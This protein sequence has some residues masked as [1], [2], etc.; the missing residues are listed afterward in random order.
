MRQT[1][2]LC[3]FALIVTPSLG[4]GDAAIRK[5]D[6]ENGLGGWACL[7]ATDH[8]STTDAQ[9]AV[10]EGQGAME[11]SFKQRTSLG[12][13]GSGIW[14]GFIAVTLDDA[15]TDLASVSLAVASAYSTGVGVMLVEEDG[16]AYMTGA[17]S[18][19]GKWS[20]CVLSTDDFVLARGSEDDNAQLDSDQIAQVALGDVGVLNHLLK[21]MGAPLYVPEPVQMT[22]WVDE[23][24][25]SSAP[26]EQD[27]PAAADAKIVPIDACSRDTIQWLPIGGEE[28]R[29]ETRTDEDDRPQYLEVGFAAP[30]GTI[31]GVARQFGA[32]ALADCKTVV[33]EMKV[34]IGGP[35]AIG[36]EDQDQNHYF[37]MQTLESSDEWQQ[38]TVSLDSL[39]LAPEPRGEDVAPAPE[40]FTA[41]YIADI[42][43][44]MQYTYS[45]NTWRIRNVR[46]EK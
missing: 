22:L 14:P 27:T 16:S 26:V 15:P 37:A 4:Q 29:M 44:A 33:A 10:F 23:I 42:L 2:A 17:W 8:V 43:G 3:L 24:V 18:E 28:V 35:V 9:D 45:A 32:G 25:L 20:E 31:F 13:L 40:K 30:P 36:F 6:F 12:G 1:L 11:F 41:V 21:Q 34:D 46:A 19:A 39:E 38:V 7:D 5:W